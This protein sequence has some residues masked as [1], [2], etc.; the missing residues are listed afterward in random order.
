MEK[1]QELGSSWNDYNSAR[2]TPTDSYDTNT[3]NI[4]Y[5]NWKTWENNV[6]KVKET[7]SGGTKALKKDDTFNPPKDSRNRYERVAQAVEVV[8]EG[9]IVLGTEKILKWKKLPIWYALSQTQT[10]L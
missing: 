8:Y 1:I 4:L 6:Y 10:K 9:C 3:L 7:T 5:F 2:Y